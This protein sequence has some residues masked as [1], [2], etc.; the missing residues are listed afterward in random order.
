[1]KG[2]Y[3]IAEKNIEIISLYEGVH[4]LCIGYES[5][6]APDFTVESAQSDIDFERER[7]AAEDAAAGRK[8]VHYSDAYLET[9]AVYRKIADKMLFYGT[10]LFHGSAIAVDGKAYLFTAKSGTGKS[11]H[12]RLW[13]E[14]FGERAVM[15]NDDKPLIHLTKEGAFVYGTPWNGKHRLGTNA[16]APLA[17]V[18]I[19]ERDTVNHIEKINAKSVYPMVMQQAHR[20]ASQG[21]MIMLFTLADVLVDTV[22][23]YR[24]GCNMERDAASVAYEGMKNNSEEIEK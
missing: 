8:T 21:G 16:S 17:A 14:L 13:R 10:M 9:L 4:K 3:R 22:P 1:M 23:F 2:T 11:T 5:E 7:S 20:P 18:C 24:L 12:T 19:L 15:I 6:E